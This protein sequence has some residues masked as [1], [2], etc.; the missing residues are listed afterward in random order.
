MLIGF[1]NAARWSFS[2]GHVDVCLP[3]PPDQLT[4][5]PA[6]LYAYRLAQRVTYR[7]KSDLT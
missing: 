6:K 3:D 4:A 5:D 2:H 7:T 1:L